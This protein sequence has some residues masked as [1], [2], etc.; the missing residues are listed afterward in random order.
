MQD[1][2]QETAPEPEEEEEEEEEEEDLSQR[3]C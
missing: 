2:I 3:G 1:E